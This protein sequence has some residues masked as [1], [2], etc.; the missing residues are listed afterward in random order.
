[1][2]CDWF[3]PSRQACVI[4][5]LHFLAFYVINSAVVS[6][7]NKLNDDN[8]DVRDLQDI[9]TFYGKFLQGFLASVYVIIIS[10]LGDKTFFIAAILSI[11]NPRLLVYCGA[12]FALVSM[13]VLSALLGYAVELLPRYY[14]YYMSGFLFIL[15]GLKMLKDGN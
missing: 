5:L 11:D 3:V 12:M 1:M 10:E 4:F 14:T 6:Q 13:T 15:F 2:W 7:K 8:S 9:Q